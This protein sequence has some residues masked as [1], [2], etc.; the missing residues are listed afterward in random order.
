MVEMKYLF[1]TKC[2]PLGSLMC[3]VFLCFVAFPCGLLGRVLYLIV[4]IPD[5]CLLPFL[6]VYFERPE[7]ELLFDYI[8]GNNLICVS[9]QGV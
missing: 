1:C 5:L 8:G 3:G 2:W 4:W 7:R 9:L 6:E